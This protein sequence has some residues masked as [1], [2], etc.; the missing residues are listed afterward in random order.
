MQSPQAT[1]ASSELSDSAPEVEDMSLDEVNGLVYVPVIL[2]MGNQFK[3]VGTSYVVKL[4]WSL[5]PA[6]EIATNLKIIQI[7]ANGLILMT[8]TTEEWTELTIYA[9]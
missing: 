9:T 7:G 6:Y 4:I 8:S 1:F 2:Y 3:L 5:N